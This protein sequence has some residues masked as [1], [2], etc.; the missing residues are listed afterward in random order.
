[1]EPIYL[2][3]AA[4]TPVHPDVWEAMLPFYTANY[5]NPSSTHSFGRAART[6]LNRFRDGMA[7][8]LGCLPG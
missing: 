1:M 2:D 8:S 6:A 3:H 7:R 5:G 4:T